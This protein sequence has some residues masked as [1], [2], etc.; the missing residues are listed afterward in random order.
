MEILASVAFEKMKPE[1]ILWIIA[2][3]ATNALIDAQDNEWK[4][5]HPLP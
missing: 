5:L 2:D 4:F 3:F 1:T